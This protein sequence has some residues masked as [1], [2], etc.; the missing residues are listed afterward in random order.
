MLPSSPSFAGTNVNPETETASPG[1]LTSGCPVD[2]NAVPVAVKCIVNPQYPELIFCSRKS[3][4]I[5]SRIEKFRS[6]LAIDN[7]SVVCLN[8]V[9]ILIGRFWPTFRRA[10]MDPS[11]Q[12]SKIFL[13]ATI[14]KGCVSSKIPPTPRGRYD[15]W[16]IRLSFHFFSSIFASTAARI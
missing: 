14:I 3:A 16:L 7:L 8:L 1:S 4:M 11:G 2:V 13:I 9:E 5:K 10:S 15:D 6:L 12:S